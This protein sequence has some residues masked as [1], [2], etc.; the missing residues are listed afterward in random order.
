MKRIFI[1]LAASLAFGCAHSPSAS[2][3]ETGYAQG[4]LKKGD[5]AHCVVC[6]IKSGSSEEM[7]VVETVDYQGKTYAFCDPK[8]KAEFL[9]D[10][11][12]YASKP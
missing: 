1:L 9:A 2:K 6:S 4:S 7:T 3:F 11:S 8:E 5:K 10:P 12:R